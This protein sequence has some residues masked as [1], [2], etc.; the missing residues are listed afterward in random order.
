MLSLASLLNLGTQLCRA[1]LVVEVNLH[2][3][4]LPLLHIAH[5]ATPLALAP[6]A[7]CPFIVGRRVRFQTKDLDTSTRGLVHNYASAYNLGIVKDQQRPLW[8][9]LGKVTEVALRNFAIAIYEEFGV[10]SVLQR[11][12]GYTLIGQLIVKFIYIYLSLHR[13]SFYVWALQKYLYY[14]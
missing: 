7:E 8:Q 9:L 10:C 6:Y 5:N 3:A 1:T 14:L 11:E 12:L 4:L 13:L 2:E